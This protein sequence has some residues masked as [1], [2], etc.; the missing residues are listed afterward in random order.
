MTA[1][2]N[3][4]TYKASSYFGKTAVMVTEHKNGVEFHLTS[5][6]IK[7]QDHSAAIR[8]IARKIAELGL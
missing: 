7:T 3:G 5:K 4:K 1:T 2:I 6:I 8:Y